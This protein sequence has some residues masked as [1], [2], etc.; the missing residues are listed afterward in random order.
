MSNIGPTLPVSIVSVRDVFPGTNQVTTNFPMPVSMWELPESL[1]EGV[2]MS[3]TRQWKR[4]C[5]LTLKCEMCS[6]FREANVQHGFCVF[7]PVFICP[8][9]RCHINVSVSLARFT[10]RRFSQHDADG[11][12]KCSDSVSL[13]LSFLVSS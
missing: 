2:V 10:A 13:S 8:G 6:T 7:V 5:P 12:A 4:L 1:P 11:S 3:V 9:D